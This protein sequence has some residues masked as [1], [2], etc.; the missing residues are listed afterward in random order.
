MFNV[1]FVLGKGAC[2]ETQGIYP[3]ET[4]R[5]IQNGHPTYPIFGH[6][7]PLYGCTLDVLFRNKSATKVAHALDYLEMGCVNWSI[8]DPSYSADPST[9]TSKVPKRMAV[10]HKREGIYGP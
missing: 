6:F 7:G 10:I 2:A 5:A 9:W 8:E 1:P 4:I 3:T